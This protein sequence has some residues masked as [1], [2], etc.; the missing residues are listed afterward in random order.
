MFIILKKSHIFIFVLAVCVVG[1]CVGMLTD[2]TPANTTPAT[3]NKVVIDAGHGGM[4]GGAT[5][6]T[7][8]VLEKDINLKVA[9]YL[10]E[11]LEQSGKTVVMTRDTDR[12]LSTTQS[13][14][15]RNQK[16]S[17]L[18]SRKKTLEEHKDGIFVSIHM[19]KFEQPQYRGAQVFYASNEPSRALAERVQK[20]L[21]EG[22]ADG[23]TRVVKPVPPEVYVLK[24]CTSTAIV[25]ECGFLSNEQ[26]EKLLAS[27]DYQRKV[28]QCIFNGINQ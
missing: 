20:S 22:L 6:N 8:G 7:T 28:A 2:S 24:G 11:M 26:E 18:E 12:S 23:N 10:K 1:L 4:D 25:A 13:A 9:G 21:I 27:E 19:N 17:D 15:I 5:G 14:K 3:S 16:K